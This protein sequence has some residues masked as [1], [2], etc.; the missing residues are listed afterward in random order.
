MTG[1]AR[2]DSMDAFH[3]SLAIMGGFLPL[4]VIGPGKYSIDVS[5]DLAVP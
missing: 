4:H 5:Y 2:V 1:M 3:K